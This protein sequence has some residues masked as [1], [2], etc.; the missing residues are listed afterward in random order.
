MMQN[1]Q[2]INDINDVD[3]ET[4]ESAISKVVPKETL[5]LIPQKLIDMFHKDFYPKPRIT[6]LDAELSTNL[7]INWMIF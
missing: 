5:T 3:V 6:L 7:N 4:K 2:S 1:C